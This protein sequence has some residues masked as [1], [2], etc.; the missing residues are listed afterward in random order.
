[1]KRIYFFSIFSFIWLLGFIWFTYSIPSFVEDPNSETDAI[2]VLTGG[3]GRFIEGLSLLK[4]HKAKKLFISGIGHNTS[5]D[6]LKV[7]LEK[8]DQLS[9]DDLKDKI[10]LGRNATNTKENALET[11]I[12]LQQQNYH[13]IRLVT[14]SYHIIRSLLE[15]RLIM[16]D[17]TIITNPIFTNKFKLSQWWKFPGSAKL[18]FWEY[19]KYLYIM[20]SN[21]LKYNLIR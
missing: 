9:L 12:W 10:E 19:N 14:S 3:K 7:L 4:N 2:I 1:M 21:I 13:T 15:F 18:L 5:F 8:Q 6:N 17:I 20:F 16:P 11:K